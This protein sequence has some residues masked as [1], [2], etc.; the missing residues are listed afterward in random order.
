M[1]KLLNTLYVTSEG[2]WLNKDGNNV[3]VRIDGAERGRAPAHLV[4]QIVCFGRV[5]MS[6]ELMHFCAG[7]GI[8]ITFLSA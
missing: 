5:G 1:K 2:A 3:V 7:E 8:S 4:G 6:P